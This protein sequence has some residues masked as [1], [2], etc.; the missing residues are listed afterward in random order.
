[1]VRVVVDI[2]IGLEV[3]IRTPMRGWQQMLVIG[4]HWSRGLKSCLLIGSWSHP[5]NSSGKIAWSH[6]LKT[7][8]LIVQYRPLIGHRWPLICWWYRS[9]RSP[10]TGSD[11]VLW[12]QLRLWQGGPAVFRGGPAMFRGGPAV[13]R[14]GPAKFRGGP[15]KIRGSLAKFKGGPAKFRRAQPCLGVVQPCSGVAQPCL[16]VAQLCLGVPSHV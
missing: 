14:G 12:L 9:P 2:L 16:G 7:C 11:S 3:E 5:P 4:Y 8:P 15:A 1:M 13:F 10:Q 6:D